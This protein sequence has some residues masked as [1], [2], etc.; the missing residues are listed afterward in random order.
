[1]QWRRQSLSHLLITIFDTSVGIVAAEIGVYKRTS[2]PWPA[3]T[4]CGRWKRSVWGL[5]ENNSNYCCS[6]LY[7][8]VDFGTRTT[9][10]RTFT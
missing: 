10:K 3:F 4:W 9:R 7:A 2:S 6:W 1:M 8:T 5:S